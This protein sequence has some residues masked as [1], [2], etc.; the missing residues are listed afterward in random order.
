MRGVVLVFV[1]IA[2]TYGSIDPSSVTV[3]GFSSGAFMATQYQFAFSSSISG[4]AILAGGPYYCAQDQLTNAF[5][6]CMY[7]ITPVP[8]PTLES[9]ARSVEASGD[10][11]PLSNLENHKVFILSGLQD[12]TV[13]SSV[14]RSLETMYQNFGVTNIKSNFQLASAHTFPTTDYGNS[15]AFSF[16]PYISNCN[17]DGAGES[18]SYLYDN[19][20]DSVDPDEEN[21][22]NIPQGRFTEGRTVASLSLGPDAF[23]YIPTGCKNPDAVCKLHVAFHGCQQY[24][25]AIGMQYVLNTGYNG[26]AEANNI[27][28]LY[29][30]ATSSTLSPNNPNGCWDWWGYL[31][32]NFAIKSGPQMVTINNMINW[33]I[34]NY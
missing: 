8:L 31:G 19:L 6:T 5:L 25:N 24:R 12:A 33:V 32:S 1:F 30:Q 13:K 26:W 28:I 9:Y 15:C 20:K 18:L 22:V 27:F 17:Y 3:S 4:A 16:T 11:D 23:L 21:I 14:V 10:I 2:L 7:G 29:P 34:E